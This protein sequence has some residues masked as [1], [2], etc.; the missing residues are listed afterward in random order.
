[1]E[2]GG[3]TAYRKTHVHPQQGQQAARDH[4]ANKAESMA[5]GGWDQSSRRVAHPSASLRGRYVYCSFV[6]SLG[7]R[8]KGGDGCTLTVKITGFTCLPTDPYST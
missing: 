1:V 4:S 3:S 7:H 6:L 2:T 8:E 5:L